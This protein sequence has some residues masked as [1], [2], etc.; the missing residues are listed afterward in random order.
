[1]LGVVLGS[2]GGVKI[3]TVFLK[4]LGSGW[5]SGALVKAI[6]YRIVRSTIWAWSWG[7]GFYGGVAWGGFLYFWVSFFWGGQKNMKMQDEIG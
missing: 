6:L 5:V 1:M 2:T 4:K 7:K 3:G